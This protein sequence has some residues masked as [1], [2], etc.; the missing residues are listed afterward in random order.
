MTVPW[1]EL[2]RRSGMSLDSLAEA[3]HVVDTAGLPRT[4]APS[5]LAAGDETRLRFRRLARAAVDRLGGLDDRLL[6]QLLAGEGAH[7]EQ[8][9]VQAKRIRELER[10]LEALGGL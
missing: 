3:L 9:A 1:V 4:V 10:R 2:L 8:L 6:E 7:R 5:W